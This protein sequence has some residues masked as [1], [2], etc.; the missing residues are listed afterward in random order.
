MLIVLPLLVCMLVDLLIHTSGFFHTLA[1]ST[2]LST[3]LLVGDYGK[4]RHLRLGR[5]DLPGWIRHQSGLIYALDHSVMVSQPQ[6]VCY[7]G[8]ARITSGSLR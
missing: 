1:C 2:W 6:L 8:L 5:V 7:Q 3:V 4:L